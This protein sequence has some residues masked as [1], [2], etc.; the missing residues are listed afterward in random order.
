MQ[1]VFLLCWL[2]LKQYTQGYFL[3]L[4][5]AYMH[6]YT[7]TTHVYA[8][9]CIHVHTKKT[10]GKFSEPWILQDHL[11]LYLYNTKMTLEGSNVIYISFST[12]DW[13]LSS[14]YLIVL[15]ELVLDNLPVSF[16]LHYSVIISHWYYLL[17]EINFS[18]C[19]S[20]YSELRISLNG[21]LHC[22]V[23]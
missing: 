20:G 12:F 22:H 13:V 21:S 8:H 3:S 18:H 2:I 1:L 5:T 23:T 17:L 19:K 15:T 11:C 9:I 4:H 16:L 10:N 7:N 6:T 14:S